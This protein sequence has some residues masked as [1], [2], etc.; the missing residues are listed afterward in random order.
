MHIQY[1]MTYLLHY[2]YNL[3]TKCDRKKQIVDFE[4][5]LGTSKKNRLSR[6]IIIIVNKKHEIN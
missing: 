4:S 3:K 2:F 6:G 5:S 1:F